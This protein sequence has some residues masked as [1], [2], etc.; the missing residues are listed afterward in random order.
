MD[1]TL[2]KEI[3]AV[4]M[5]EAQ[6]A[7]PGNVPFALLLLDLL[8][9]LVTPGIMVT[10]HVCVCVCAHSLSLSPAAAQSVSPGKSQYRSHDTGEGRDVVMQNPGS[11]TTWY[12]VLWWLTCVKEQTHKRGCKVTNSQALR[13]SSSYCN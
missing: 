2:V 11:R 1:V 10:S 8:D 6:R 7:H 9:L 4:F 12:R 5:V 3:G 13:N